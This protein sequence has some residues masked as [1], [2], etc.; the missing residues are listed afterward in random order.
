MGSGLNQGL[1]CH[2]DRR[3]HMRKYPEQA[4]VRLRPVADIPC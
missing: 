2:D 1:V 4:I 3:R